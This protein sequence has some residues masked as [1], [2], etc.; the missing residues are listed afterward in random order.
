MVLHYPGTP[1]TTLYGGMAT[2]A[3]GSLVTTFALENWGAST[4]RTMFRGGMPF[5]KGD[6]PAGYVPQIRRQDGP[7]VA[8]QFDERSTWSDGSLKFAVCHLRDDDLSASGTAVYDVYSVVGAFDNTGTVSLS[9]V[10][11]SDALTVELSSLTQWDGSTSTTRGSGAALA[12][13][14]AHAAVSTRVT[15]VHSGPVCEGWEVWGMFKDGAAGDGSEDA[16]LKVIWHVDVWKDASG[17]VVDAEFAAEMA[18]D[19]W[20][21]AGKYRLDYTATLKRNGSTVQAYTGV[22]HPYHGH[23]ATVRLQ[24]D[25]NH[26][27]RHWASA[28]PTLNYKFSKAYWKSTKVVP[29]YDVNYT[30]NTTEKPTYVPLGNIQHRAA[31][32]ATGAYGGRGVHT[33]FDAKAFMRQTAFDNRVARTN[34]FAGLHLPQHYRDER[35]RTRPS[36]SADVANTL[37]P[38]LWEPK[39][40]SA[41]TFAGLP[42]P[43]HAY[44][45]SRTDL[46]RQGGFVQPTGGNGVWTPSGDGSHAVAYSTYAYILEGERYMLNSVI[47]MATK[48]THV[49]VGGIY[50]SCCY[51]HWYLED[52]ARTEMSIPNTVWTALPDT[53]NG[54][55]RALGFGSNLVGHAAGLVPDDDLQ[56]DYLRGWNAHCAEYLEQSLLYTPPALKSAGL[57]FPRQ[58]TRW[59]RNPWMAGAN[60]QCL[61]YIYMLTEQQG[62]ADYAEMLG[63]FVA[64]VADRSLYLAGAYQTLHNYK[65]EAYSFSSQNLPANQFLSGKTITVTSSRFTLSGAD[66]VAPQAGDVVYFLDY[67][68]TGGPASLPP[69]VAAGTKYY[70]VDPAGGSW[71]LAASP[72]GSA[73]SLTNGT[74]EIGCQFFG[75]NGYTPATYPPYLPPGGDQYWSIALAAYAFAEVAGS[76]TIPAG[77]A[78]EMESFLSNVN[79]ADYPAWVMTVED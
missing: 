20:G 61:S 31:I 30:P 28:I 12:S 37:V 9:S 77:L 1:G 39:P 73:I 32:D 24:D 26:A 70:L 2:P 76:A 60:I 11:A 78:A 58:A 44:A 50:G 52:G 74:Y 27:R 62:F 22:Q 59:M 4:S 5:K 43:K 67:N 21:V 14:A 63:N 72:G 51:I 68:Y 10:A 66:G 46:D 45:D 75:Q 79:R 47:D 40:A 15:K 6:I 56:G 16:H 42:T 54:Q 19:W 34:A 13:F 55:E 53:G 36:E 35:T 33:N 41:S 7:I 23:W 8:A 57:Q 18:Q 48:A 25:N 71:G 38:L 17:N 69:E 64:A 65:N 29:Q 49:L 3:A